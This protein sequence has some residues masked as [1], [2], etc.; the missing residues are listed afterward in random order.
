VF[1]G[2]KVAITAYVPAAA[3]VAAPPVRIPITLPGVFVP[4][5]VTV[6]ACPEPLYVAGELFTVTVA[7]ETI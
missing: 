4:L 5:K 1:N 2:T 6:A 3:C 7:V